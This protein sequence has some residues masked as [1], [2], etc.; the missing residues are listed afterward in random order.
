M[1][2]VFWWRNLTER[3]KLR[4]LV[5]DGDN[6]KMNVQEIGRK[7]CG[8]DSICPEVGRMAGCCE[9]GDE[10]SDSRNYGKFLD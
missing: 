8:F 10:P 2:T 7:R 3:D 4:D 5:V 9:Y 6:I 1:H